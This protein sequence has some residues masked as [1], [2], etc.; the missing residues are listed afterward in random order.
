MAGDGGVYVVLNIA[1]R[2]DS[3][4]CPENT[5]AAFRSAVALGVDMIELDVWWTRDRQLVVLHD[6]TV[7]RCT[8]GSGAVADLT[9]AEIKTLDAGTWKAPQFAGETVPTLAEAC[10][11]IP[12]PIAV[13]LHLKT[14]TDDPD[15]TRQTYE[16][17]A[18]GGLLG[19]LLVVHDH[20]P[21]L[22]RW[23]DLSE[24][25]DLCLLPSSP[26]WPEYLAVAQQHGFWVLQPGRDMMGPEFCQAAHAQGLRAN[27][28][29]ADTAADMRQFVAWGIDGILTNYPARLAQVLREPGGPA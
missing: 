18:A 15:F 2:G 4:D 24:G 23:R 10:A 25:F 6:P 16:T 8:D 5:V 9:L 28:F 13:N 3:S 1:H 26:H 19:R 27:V 29:Y 22:E 20:R 12:A 11:A 17:V 7:D 14:E 21:T